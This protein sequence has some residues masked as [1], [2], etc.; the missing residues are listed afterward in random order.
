MKPIELQGVIW[1]KFG[2]SFI[3]ILKNEKIKY[4][5]CKGYK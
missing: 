3:K 4:Y 2:D 1:I 5:K